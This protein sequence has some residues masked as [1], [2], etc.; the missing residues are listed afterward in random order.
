MTEERIKA[1]M[2]PW[3]LKSIRNNAGST[4][5]SITSVPEELNTKLPVGVRIPIK[6]NTPVTLMHGDSYLD[7]DFLNLECDFD[8]IGT[9]YIIYFK[10][11][12]K[13]DTLDFITKVVGEM[14]RLRPLTGREMIRAV[15]E[16]DE[17]D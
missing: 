11:Y 17:H 10:P 7:C 16:G 4:Y 8:T 6:P 2:G 14:S 13:K 12:D 1:N 15:I 5:D 9:P 3:F